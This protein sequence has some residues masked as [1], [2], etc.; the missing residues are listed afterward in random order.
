M[1]LAAARW[2]VRM[3]V[4]PKLRH[5]RVGSAGASPVVLLK[6]RLKMMLIIATQARLR[7]SGNR[8]LPKP[9]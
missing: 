5:G 8:I 9:L 7:L 2:L 3:Q 1:E 6:H 4:L